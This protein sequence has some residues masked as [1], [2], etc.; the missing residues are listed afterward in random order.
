M[1]SVRTDR[2]EFVK[3]LAAAGVALAVPHARRSRSPTHD[4]PRTT[5]V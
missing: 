4:A 5:H 1:R 3:T 2:R